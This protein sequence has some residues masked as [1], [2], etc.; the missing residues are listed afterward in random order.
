MSAYQKQNREYEYAANLPDKLN[1][2]TKKWHIVSL[3]N[4]LNAGQKWKAHSVLCLTLI[5]PPHRHQRVT[6]A[7]S[8]H[9][10]KTEQ[11][12]QPAMVLTGWRVCNVRDVSAWGTPGRPWRRS[13]TASRSPLPGNPWRLSFWWCLHR[14]LR[15]HAR[16]QTLASTELN[17]NWRTTTDINRH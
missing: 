3:F 10:P 6:D 12:P 2:R 9:N 5:P 4:H 1:T 13:C 8:Q 11:T 14:E 15:E 16:I 7:P 17:G